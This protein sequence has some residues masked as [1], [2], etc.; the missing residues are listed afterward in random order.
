MLLPLHTSGTFRKEWDHFKS[1]WK[2]GPV[3]TVH[4]RQASSLSW[5]SLALSMRPSPSLSNLCSKLYSSTPVPSTPLI[6]RYWRTKPRANTREQYDRIYNIRTT[7]AVSACMSQLDYDKRQRDGGVWHKPTEWWQKLLCVFVF[8]DTIHSIQWARWQKHAHH[9]SAAILGIALQFVM[10]LV[11]EFLLCSMI[12][13]ATFKTV[14]SM[15]P[16]EKNDFKPQSTM[17]QQCIYIL[18]QIKRIL[19]HVC[20]WLHLIH[21]MHVS[22]YSWCTPMSLNRI[23]LQCYPSNSTTKDYSKMEYQGGNMKIQCPNHS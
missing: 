6:K 20:T 9:S 19:V 22:S 8:G 14:L 18:F 16:V 13:L 4:E 17:K 2:L 23:S 3:F 21:L 10:E 15:F 5:V 1:M 12:G 7:R 11:I